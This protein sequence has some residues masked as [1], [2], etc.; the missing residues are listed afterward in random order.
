M[1][2]GTYLT[3]ADRQPTTTTESRQLISTTSS[4]WVTLELVAVL[5]VEHVAKPLALL[6]AD[7]SGI[8]SWGCPDN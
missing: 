4:S 1:T 3:F 8:R 6:V 2:V 5:S 7:L